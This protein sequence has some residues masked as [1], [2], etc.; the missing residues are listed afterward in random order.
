M[1]LYL[2][3]AR[4]VRPSLPYLHRSVAKFHSTAAQHSPW[5]AIV[6]GG[7]SGIGKAISE[8]LASRGI[9]VLVADIQADRAKAT[10]E[11]LSETY[12]IDATSIALDV[13]KED[14]VRRMVSTVTQRWGRLDY[15]A[16]CAG[17]CESVWD[18]EESI[19]TEMVTRFEFQ[20]ANVLVSI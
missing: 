18:E 16:N 13:T 14:D 11:Y 5:T 17:V 8:K 4:A 1:L 12:D 6:T 20:S 10:A 9:N 7:A 19:T 15:A 2:R 3:F